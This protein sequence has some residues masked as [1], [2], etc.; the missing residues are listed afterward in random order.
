MKSFFRSIVPAAFALA[1]VAAH[2]EPTGGCAYGVYRGAASEIAALMPPLKDAKPTT[3]YA[4]VAGRRGVIDDA[5][6]PVVCENGALHA[7]AGDS[8]PWSRIALRETPATFVSHGLHLHGMLTELADQPAGAKPPLLVLVHGS[9]QTS[10]IGLWQQLLFTAQGIS[11]FAFDKRGTGQSE[12]VYT[13]DFNLL[14]DDA[15]AAAREAK[16]IAAGRFGRLG[17][18]GGSQGGWVA[19]R[20]ARLAHADFVEVGFGVVGTPLE[21]DQW[22]VDDEL[23]RKGFDPSIL[24][25]VH[26][27]TDATARVAASNFD[28]HL[29]EIETLRARFGQT[30]WF[31]KIEGQYSG[32]VLRGEIERAKRESPAVPWPYPATAEM[33]QV[34]VPQLWVLA[35]DDSIAPSARTVE[36]LLELDRAGADIGVVV[37]PD[38]DHGI[39]HFTTAAD[40]TRTSGD[41][42]EGYLRMLADWAKGTWAPPYG[43]ADVKRAPKT[44]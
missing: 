38:T 11:T 25:D 22:Q 42:A 32:L 26:A 3:R 9:E 35:R 1:C 36:R 14:A 27:V 4:T 17:L 39:R 31:A 43:T 15:A 5:T 34:R 41:F 2:A 28:R 30:P 21:Q 24:A 44:R 37:F 8:S 20:A 29:D 6:S 13:Q 10:P 7:R 16:R 33:K 40:G 19:P 18:Y 23:R 12:G